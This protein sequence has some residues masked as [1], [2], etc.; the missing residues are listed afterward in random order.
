LELKPISKKHLNTTKVLKVGNPKGFSK[1]VNLSDK[2]GRADG[3][4][5]VGYCYLQGIGIEKDDCQAFIW[6]K[7]SADMNNSD[8][9]LYLVIAMNLEL[10]LKRMSIRLSHTIKNQQV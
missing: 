5:Q 7:E 2:M 8:E 10:M 3:M 4:L 9:Y 6:Y 1:T